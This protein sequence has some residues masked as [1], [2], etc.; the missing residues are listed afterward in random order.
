MKKL[1]GKLTKETL[2]I[3]LAVGVGLLPFI[4]GK[5][6]VAIAVGATFYYATKKE[7]FDNLINRIMKSIGSGAGAPPPKG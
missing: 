7:A 3:A 1:L 4:L 5:L 2:T 6:G